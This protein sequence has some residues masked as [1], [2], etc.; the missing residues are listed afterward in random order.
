MIQYN[1]IHIA[2]KHYVTFIPEGLTQKAIQTIS[3]K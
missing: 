2:N 3:N 1:S